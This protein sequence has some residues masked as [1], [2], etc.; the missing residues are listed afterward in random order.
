MTSTTLQKREKYEMQSLH[1]HNRITPNKNEYIYNIVSDA[2]E[3]RIGIISSSSNI[4]LYSLNNNMTFLNSLSGHTGQV[5]SLVFQTQD[6]IASCSEDANVCLFDTRNSNA[7][8]QSLNMGIGCLNTIDIQL[9]NNNILAV[10]GDTTI[11]LRDLRNFNTPLYSF[12]DIHTMPIRKVKFYSDN[13]L[14]SSA[15]DGLVHIYALNNTSTVEDPEDC[16]SGVFNGED[17][18]HQFGLCGSQQNILYTISH[19]HELSFWNM[20]NC[21]RIGLPLSRSALELISPSIEQ[22]TTS[23]TGAELMTDDEM[24][25]NYLIDAQYFSTTDSMYAYMGTPN[26]TII[27]KINMENSQASYVP[28]AQLSG[29]KDESVVIRGIW[30][31]KSG[32]FDKV[33]TGG[34][35]GAVCTYSTQPP[36]AS[37]SPV[38]DKLRDSHEETQKSSRPYN[39]NKNNDDGKKNKNNKPYGGGGRGGKQHNK[40]RN[41]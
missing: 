41:K 39:R 40:S 19:M 18:I 32:L 30:A 3:E 25:N 16:L 35:D 29:N 9:E 8:L 20:E 26:G 23:S 28:V 38:F 36:R 17:G 34:E 1:L 2:A 37:T 4:K 14:F 27:C 24:S 6:T 12:P 21:T 33:V 13:R 7:A 15:D 5:T 22:T 31:T 10:G 11:Q